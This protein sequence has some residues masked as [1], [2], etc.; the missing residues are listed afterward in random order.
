MSL[1][2]RIAVVLIALS[3]A[4]AGTQAGKLAFGLLVLMPLWVP[5]LAIWCSLVADNV[6]FSRPGR[7]AGSPPAQTPVSPAA[8]PAPRPCAAAPA[9]DGVQRHTHRHRR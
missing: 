7:G 4:L 8:R 1:I 2:A 3:V 9:T 5:L 6:M